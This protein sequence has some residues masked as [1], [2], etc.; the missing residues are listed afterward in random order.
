M[1]TKERAQIVK[2]CLCTRNCV[3]TK[4]QQTQTVQAETGTRF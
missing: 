4:Q 2:D 3:T 1:I